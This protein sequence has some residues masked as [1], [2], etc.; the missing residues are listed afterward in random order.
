MCVFVVIDKNSHPYS[1]E[2]LSYLRESY[3]TLSNENERRQYDLRLR[4]KALKRKKNGWKNTQIVMKNK[5]ENINA[6]MQLAWHRFHHGQG[7]KEVE[8]LVVF[9]QTK[10]NHLLEVIQHFKLLPSPLDQVIF[11]GEVLLSAAPWF[12]VGGMLWAI[13]FFLQRYG[14]SQS[15]IDIFSV[16]N[17]VRNWGSK[18]EELQQ[19]GIIQPQFI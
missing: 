8:D 5:M 2:A 19:R 16:V 13:R 9:L 10:L 15:P 1:G 3:A 7:W 17:I 14:S 6:R 11:L 18:K 12:G 4:Q